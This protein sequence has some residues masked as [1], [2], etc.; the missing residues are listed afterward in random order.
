MKSCIYQK[1]DP[2]NIPLIESNVLKS[3]LSL[4][5]G[6]EIYILLA[7]WNPLKLQA[8]LPKAPSGYNIFIAGLGP[9]GF[10]LSYYLT[11]EGHNICAIDGLSIAKLQFDHNAPIRNWQQIAQNLDQRMPQGFGGVAE[12]GITNRWDKNYLTLI[13]ILLQRRS[14]FAMHGA[15][16]LGGNIT[17]EQLWEDGFDHVAICTGTGGPK[18]LNAPNATAKGVRLAADFLM[19][20]QQGGA[21]LQKGN[22][23]LLL[24]LPVAVIGGGLT[25]I[26]AAVEAMH[27]YPLQ[28]EKF[29]LWYEAQKDRS[30]EFNTQEQELIAEFL[31]HHELLSQAKTTPEK[32]AIMQNLGGVTI[33]YR[34]SMEQAPAYQLNHEEIEQALAIGVRF[35]ENKEPITIRV[36]RDNWVDSIDFSDGTNSKAAS[37]LIAIGNDANKFPDFMAHFHMAPNDSI[38]LTKERDISYFGD[39]N[40]LYAGSVVKAIASSKDNYQIISAHLRKKPPARSDKIQLNLTAKVQNITK[41]QDNLTE[42]VIKAPYGARNFRPGHFFKLQNFTHD[43]ALAMEPL[44]LSSFDVNRD[45]GEIKLIVADIG[46][47]SNLCKMLQ[48]GQEVNL[49]GPTGSAIEIPSDKFVI[50]IGRDAASASLMPVMKAAKASGC[51]ILY[52]ACYESVDSIFHKE[53]FE[54]YSDKVIWCLQDQPL[55]KDVRSCDVMIQGDAIQALSAMLEEAA[56][57]VIDRIICMDAASNMHSLQ[58]FCSKKIPGVKLISSVNAPMQCM[59]KAICGQCVVK[60]ARS[61]NG[62]I[63]ACSCQIQ[64]AADIDFVSVQARLEQNRLF[65]KLNGRIRAKNY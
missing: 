51:Y 43:P 28:L 41:L 58:D 3:V 24:R 45:S 59:M 47:T 22:S 38:F 19:Q 60:S 4:P 23:N 29:Y 13:S 1:Q 26:D 62:L 49:M 61:E 42:L 36:G 57:K 21:F 46:K 5:W 44:A 52:I 6:A 53:I 9:A 8:Y 33:Y 27:Y 55:L 18:L 15:V 20:L 50:L 17:I 48:P 30:S 12:Y 54:Y 64:E 63:F 31:Q 32:I 39:C 2:V 34:R 16:R 10:S 37:V 11:Q 65:E 14:N 35:A 7:S 25:A 56:D 40:P